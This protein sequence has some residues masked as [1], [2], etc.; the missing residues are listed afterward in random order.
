MTDIVRWR[1][2]LLIRVLLL[3]LL[4]VFVLLNALSGHWLQGRRLDLTQDRLYTLSPGT[5][6][7]LD[8]IREP[9]ELDLYFSER[10][11]RGLPSLRGYQQ[12]VRETLE[13][14]ARNA[15]RKLRFRSID[16]QPYSEDEDRAVSAGLRA[17]PVGAS[18]ERVLFG[19]AGHSKD[20]ANAVIAFF[21]PDKEA[22]LEY[23]LAKLVHDL[24]RPRRPLIGILTS[25]PM[26][27]ESTAPGAEPRPWAILEQLRQ[28]FQVRMLDPAGLTRIDP[29]L[30]VLLLA[31]PRGLDAAAERAI[32]RYVQQGGHV[33]A[34]VDPVPE[35]LRAETAP[36]AVPMQSLLAAWGVAFDP[37]TVV[38]DRARALAITSTIGATPIRHPA[39]LGL[40]ASELAPDDVVTANLHAID[41]SSAGVLGIEAGSG[42]SLVPLLQSTADAMLVPATRL[43][44]AAD[45]ADLYTD[46]HADGNHY[47][48][49][50]RVSGPIGSAFPQDAPA[51]P[52]TA[53]KAQI[54]VVADSDILTDRL[55][56]QVTRFFGQELYNPFA[57]NGDFVLNL[58]DNLAGSSALISIRGRSSAQRPFDRV[59]ALR[60]DADA[61]FQDRQQQLQNELGDIER[62]LGRLDAGR[63][64]RAQT[65][66]PGHKAVLEKLLKRKLAIRDEL[67]QL[68]GRLDREINALG[69]RL[70]LIDV[71]LWPLLVALLAALA[72]WWRRWHGGPRR[73][74]R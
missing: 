13:E 14:M 36:A 74:R 11:S 56:V 41:L 2:S 50:A 40:T 49:A 33:L 55:W 25:L 59:I 44:A 30:R 20:G 19:L 35:Q 28:Q 67:R 5:L 15:G 24:S 60:R 72:Q 7:V 45:A 52:T 17:V 9:I 47:V 27:G 64:D 8:N 10:A 68:Q 51:P 34:F 12:R 23:D 37:H 42:V 46:Y 38:L 73:G 70:E 31:V 43:T 18:G 65:A 32:D 58:V 66:D 1:R 63:G 29:T 57:N 22:F 4:V 62:E 61:Q 21:Q 6:R 16:P 54:V 71:V 3:A 26:Q 69:M 48:L 39:V 53:A